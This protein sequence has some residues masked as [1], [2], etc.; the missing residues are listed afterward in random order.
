MKKNRYQFDR[1][2]MGEKVM[3]A[4]RG[5]KKVFE[6]EL[7]FRIHVAI[8][9]VLILVNF[10]LGFTSTEWIMVLLVIGCLMAAEIFNTAIEDIMDAYSRSYDEKIKDIKDVSAGAVLLLTIISIIIG[11]IIYVPKFISLFS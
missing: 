8:T 11:L 3:V 4:L 9:I 5:I 2:S 6:T 7:S 10:E 1:Q